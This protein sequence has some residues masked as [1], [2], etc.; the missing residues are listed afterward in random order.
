M[1]SKKYDEAI[2]A[3]TQ[4]IAFDATNPVYFSNRAAAHSSKGD[5]LSAVAD[6]G[7]AIEIDPAFT[8]AY[9]RLG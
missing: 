8:K 7:Q 5:H 9:H 3:Y 6:A 2:E 4:A 1:S